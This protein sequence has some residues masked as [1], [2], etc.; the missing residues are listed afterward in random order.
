VVPLLVVFQSPPV[1]VDVERSGVRLQGR[2]VVDAA[3]GTRRSDL[4]E[5][6]TVEGAAGIGGDRDR[7]QKK[8]RVHVSSS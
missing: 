8:K 3:C 6:Q 1:A 7:K 4:A 2:E 5:L